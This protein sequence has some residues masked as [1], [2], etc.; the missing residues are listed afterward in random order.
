MDIL[1]QIKYHAEH[2][3]DRMAVVSEN[4]TLTYEQL[5]TYSDRLAGHLYHIYGEGEA[6]VVVYGHKQPDMLVCF[7]ACVKAGRAYCPVD[8]SVPLSRTHSIIE[9][10][11]A[12]AVLSVSPL[13]GVEKYSVVQADELK[14]IISTDQKAC[15]KDSRVSGLDTFYIIFTSGSTGTPKGVQ[16]PCEC[17]NHFLDW[18][19]DLGLPREEKYGASFLNQAPFSFDLS[20]MD[21]YTCLACGGT[22]WTLSKEV[23]SD[24]R[25]MFSVMS[26][27]H[28]K[29]WVSTPS[30]A[31]VCLADKSFNSNLLPELGTF[32]FCGETLTNRTALALLERF[33]AASVINTYGPTESTVA[34]T[35][36][37][38]TNELAQT[39]S[40]LP[41]GR[42]KPGSYIEIWDEAGNIVPEGTIGEIVILGDTV[43]TG[44]LGAPE[45]T[46][47]SFF[48]TKRDGTLIRGYHSGDSGYLKDQML[49]FGGRI[50]LQIKL[51]GYRIEVEDIEQNLLKLAGVRQ[52]AV[53]PNIKD[54]KVKSLTAYLACDLPDTKETTRS[55]KEALKE[56]LPDYMIPKKFVYLEHL[57][58]TANGKCDRKKLREIIL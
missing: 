6:P 7:L 28:A 41:V 24:Y 3:P 57:P 11:G 8:I 39:V 1:T 30:F 58:M 44:Y 49:Y 52:T 27:S 9:A 17:L 23:Q 45:L 47:R 51:H 25:K 21:L 48:E 31:D 22:L 43:S 35:D 16:I 33:P 36:V 20:V 4:E 55:L 15:P 53:I 29:V 54:D 26:K 10:S 2:S 32:L 56:H 50:D 18:A 42:T 46:A 19:C 38:I 14:Q 37:T 12:V 34:L 40:P 13:D 5:D